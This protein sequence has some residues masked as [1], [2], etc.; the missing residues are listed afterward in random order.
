MQFFRITDTSGRWVGHASANG[1]FSRRVPFEKDEQ[2]LGVLAMKR[3]VALPKVD[4]VREKFEHLLK[5]ES[6]ITL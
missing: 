1:R 3:G 6:P 2:D 4:K 5:D